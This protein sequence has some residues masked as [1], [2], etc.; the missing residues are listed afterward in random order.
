MRFQVSSKLQY[1]VKF[2]STLILNIHAQK[3]SSQT[4]VEEHFSVTPQV[5]IEE[6]HL[7]NDGNRFVRLETGNAATLD[8]EYSAT[9]DSTN[10]MVQA[11][12]VDPISIAELDS[13]VAIVSRIAWRNWRGTISVTS[14]IRIRR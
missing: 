13:P 9:V 6:F 4:I 2:P 3:S 12:G 7:E 1:S 14:R 10:A 8:V 5:P 11:S